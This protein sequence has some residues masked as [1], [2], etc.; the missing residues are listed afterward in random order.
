VRTPFR[1]DRG[2]A[3][4]EFALVL[5]ILVALTFGAIEY[6]RAYSAQVTVTNAARVAVRSLVVGGT[7]AT[8]RAAAVTAMTGLPN[9]SSI[10]TAGLAACPTDGTVPSRTV[11][12]TYSFSSLTG[13]FFTTRTITGTG[14]MLCNS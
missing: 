12:V 8:A 1:D 11:T 13:F 2:A 3:A 14:A 6:G 7:T 10:G 4:V 5:P 9:P